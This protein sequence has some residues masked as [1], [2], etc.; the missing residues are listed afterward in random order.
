VRIS[1][2][3]NQLK[4]YNMMAAKLSTLTFHVTKWRLHYLTF[5]GLLASP[6]MWKRYT[7]FLKDFARIYS[8]LD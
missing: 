8:Y 1:L 2:K 7:K 6:W 4:W 5:L 3:W